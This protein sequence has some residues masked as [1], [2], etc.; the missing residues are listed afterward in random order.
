M[1]WLLVWTAIHLHLRYQELVTHKRVV[2]MVIFMWL[3]SAFISLQTSWVSPDIS[4]RITLILGVVGLFVT[5]ISYSRIH[6]AV[7]RHKNQI[8]VL[9]IQQVAQAGEIA[10]F[11]GFIKSAVAVFYVL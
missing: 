1:L 2:A 4:S 11:A 9:Q 6:L 10:N 8:Q 3:F 5:T 7:R